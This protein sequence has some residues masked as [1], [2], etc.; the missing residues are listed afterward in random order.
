MPPRLLL[1]GLDAFPSALLDEW[2]A[3]GTLPNLHRL[4]AEGTTGH[5]T[6]D[7]DIFPGAIWPT[8]FTM[9][10]VSHHGNYHIYQW[11]P[12][13]KR[14]RPPGP[15]WC[16]VTPFWHRLGQRGLPAIVLDVPFSDTRRAAPNVVEVIG[17]GMHEGMWRTSRPAGLLRELNRR[18]PAAQEREGPGV[19]PQSDIMPELD[20]LV[21]DVERRVAVIEEL[22]ARFDWR[23]LLA[24]F[25]EVHRAGHWFWGERGTGEPQG[26]LKR[27]LRAIDAQLPRLRR[28]LGPEDHLAVFAVHG[29][30]ETLDA[31]RLGEAALL[32]IDPSL[33]GLARKVDPVW[34]LRNILPM[35]LVRY[36]ARRIP[37]PLYDWALFHLQNAGR[38][39]H[40][41]PT[42]INP[43]D[44][45]LYLHANVPDSAKA[46]HLQWLRTQVQGMRS[47]DGQPVVEEII[48]P[49][50]SYRG[51]RLALLPDL[52]VKPA[53][54]ELG[55]VFVMADGSRRRAPR[56]N[57]RDG[58]HVP[59]GF[60]IQ[61]GPGIA[62]GG[63]GPEAR[64]EA[65][66][67]L[68]LAPA[69]LLGAL[70]A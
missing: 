44:S 16:E 57:S 14:L 69:G 64:A 54:R 9:S 53:H 38:R 70:D 34:L 21:G 17:W 22:A 68:L 36:L 49:A 1:L 66:A 7:A 62:A 50:T 61:A 60:Y 59:D 31:D 25:S 5:V 20:G 37:Q 48:G 10:D 56:R 41:R 35:S 43:L 19:R 8:F 28:L 32:Y 42:I 51:A 67:R 52:V 24:V 46:A 2:C 63:R 40:Q 12:G 29:M 45:L 27:V 30:A 4:R 55:P 33:N 18:H 6:S 11:D 39:W 23:L 58:E 26:G 47:L 65:L 3:D 13:T 15:D